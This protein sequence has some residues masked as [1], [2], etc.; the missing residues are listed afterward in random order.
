M[1]T[2]T[3]ARPYGVRNIA[4]WQMN[5]TELARTV[6]HHFGY[7]ARSGGWIYRPN[8]T[9]VTQGWDSFADMLETRGYI[10]VGKG[11]NWRPM[12]QQLRL[13]NWRPAASRY[14][15]LLQTIIR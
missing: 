14:P 8:G 11:I 9:P 6:A 1:S 3:A 12:G 2:Q 4:T 15:R 10:I 7:A 13:P 5:R